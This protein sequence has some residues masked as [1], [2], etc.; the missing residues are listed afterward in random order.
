MKYMKY[1]VGCVLTEEKRE[2]QEGETE[3]GEE[4]EEA[5]KGMV[6]LRPVDTTSSIVVI[7]HEVIRLFYALYSVR[8]AQL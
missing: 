2:K 8:L 1:L 4:E 3:R 6:V 5:A 7:T